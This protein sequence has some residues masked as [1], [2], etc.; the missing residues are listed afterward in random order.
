[1]TKYR[2]ILFTGIVIFSINVLFALGSRLYNVYAHYANP[3]LT[4]RQLIAP[5]VFFLMSLPIAYMNV[6][7]LNGQSLFKPIAYLIGIIWL[8]YSFS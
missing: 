7:S 3:S 4:G 1:M 5:G 2:I 8:V 6:N